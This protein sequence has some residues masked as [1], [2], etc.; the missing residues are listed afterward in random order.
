MLSRL[1]EEFPGRLPSEILAEMDAAPV[2]LLETI[3]E[4]RAF[5]AVKRQID[6]A[7]SALD[8]PQGEMA[9]LILAIQGEEAEAALRGR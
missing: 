2:G 9:D 4:M 8:H 1:C 3:V 7:K 5:A 6:T